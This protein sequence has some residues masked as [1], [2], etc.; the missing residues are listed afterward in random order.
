MINFEVLNTY[1][2]NDVDIIFAVF[3][4]YMEDYEDGLERINQLNAEQ[5]WGTY[6]YYHTA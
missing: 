4:T 5:N 1:M 3:S 2:D 6:S